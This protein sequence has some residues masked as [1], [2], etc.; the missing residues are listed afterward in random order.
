MI[1]IAITPA[2]TRKNEHLY[3]ARVLDAGWD[4]VHLRHPYLSEEELRKII[5]TINP[6]YYPKIKLHSYPHLVEE[7]KLGGVHL[8]S[9]M[10]AANIDAQR[11]SI[12]RSCH[13]ISEVLSANNY[14]FD[15]VTLSPIFDSI[16]KEGY[17][18]VFNVE[19]L[20]KIPSIPKVIAL[21]GITPNRIEQLKQYNFAGYAVL[22]YL[23]Q[24]NSLQQLSSLLSEYN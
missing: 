18:S 9:R 17:K 8:N 13:S 21:G 3:I 19:Q 20:A 7:Y 4:W 10:P 22:G 14:G 1:K 5:D 16:S 12:S 15:Y 2:Y 11:Y 23:A 24:A 6:I